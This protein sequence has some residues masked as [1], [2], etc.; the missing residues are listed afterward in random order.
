[1]YLTAKARE[2]LDGLRNSWKNPE[3]L[4]G[5]LTFKAIQAK[6]GKPSRSF[7]NEAICHWFGTDDARTLRQWAK[8]GRRV[9]NPRGTGFN[10]LAPCKYWVEDPETGEKHPVLRGFKA[11]HVYP[12]EQT[13]GKPLPVIAP[14]SP[15]P[16]AEVA[17]RWGFRVEY[18][19]GDG[20][21]WGS[22]NPSAKVIKLHTFHPGVFYHELA[23]AA[24]EKAGTLMN[25]DKVDR[26]TVAETVAAILSRLYGDPID[27]QSWKYIRSYAASPLSRIESL[28]ARILKCVDL[29]L[30]DSQEVS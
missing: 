17:E 13:E 10:L 16:L 12:V 1:M 20:R 18:S 14:P 11:F 30:S 5:F 22:M 21:L 8:A 27:G 15:P 7:F 6:A 29:I 3:N 19:N 28:S 24:D 23:H 2:V 4:V 25:G 26:E 9:V